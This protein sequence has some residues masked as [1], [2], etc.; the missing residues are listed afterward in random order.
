MYS[1]SYVYIK[2]ICAILGIGRNTAL[3]LCQNRTHGFPAVKV[4][5]RYQVDVNKLMHWK[6]EWDAGKFTI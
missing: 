1:S 6:D 4:G 5:R 3:K 2:D